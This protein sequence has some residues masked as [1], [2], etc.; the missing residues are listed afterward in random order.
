MNKVLIV[1]IIFCLYLSSNAQHLMRKA[2]LGINV[3]EISD[4]LK[5]IHKISHG[6]YIIKINDIEVSKKHKLKTGDIILSINSIEVKSISGLVTEVS[7]YNEDNEVSFSIIR[8]GKQKQIKGTFPAKPYEKSENHEI[9]YDQFEFDEGYIR[10]IID[11]PDGDIKYPAILFIQGYTCGSIDNVGEKHPYIQ[12]VKVLCNKG[13]VVMR[14][15]KPGVG[16]CNNKT[17]CEDLD[18]NKEIASFTKG[19]RKLKTYDFVD[20]NNVFIWGHSLGGMIAPIIANREKLKGVIVYGTTIKPW[21]EYLIEMNRKQAPLF[22]ADYVESEKYA[23]NYHKLIYALYVD[24]KT[25]DEI[26]KDT[27]MAQMLK[28]H[29]MYDG[30]GHIYGR[31]YKTF[32]QID[33]Y[34]QTEY[35][36]KVNSNVLVFWGDADIEAMSRY[37]HETIVDVVNRYHP[38]KATFIHLKNTTHSFAKVESMEH[39]IKNRNWKY[40]T[41]NFNEDVA[42]KTVEWINSL[43]QQFK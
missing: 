36:S 41:E 34:N 7:K 15:E 25:P 16:D 33:D 14:M 11:K 27:I 20:T 13:Y 43:E 12:L 32:V 26:E 37:D 3:A 17:K 39:G 10:T 2:H 31:N 23:L 5:T 9:L 28:T 4:S 40:I 30:K 22:G 6:I 1:A 38:G 18:F 21:R 35:W 42:I 24:K 8:N 19:L 29:F